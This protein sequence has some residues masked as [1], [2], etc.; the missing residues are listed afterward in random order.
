[1]ILASQWSGSG[2]FNM[3]QFDLDPFMTE[4]GYWGLPWV[5][6]FRPLKTEHF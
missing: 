4:I 5:E 2:V 6:T 1:M 3:E